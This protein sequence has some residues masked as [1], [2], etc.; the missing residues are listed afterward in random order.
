MDQ[1]TNN[2]EFFTNWESQVKKGL[3]E[4][5][6]SARDFSMS[7][8]KCEPNSSAGCTCDIKMSGKICS[9]ADLETLMLILNNI[10]GFE[11]RDVDFDKVETV[12]YKEIEFHKSDEFTDFLQK[13]N[14]L[15]SGM[16]MY[17]G[18]FQTPAGRFDVNVRGVSDGIIPEIQYQGVSLDAIK[19]EKPIRS[20]F[21]YFTTLPLKEMS[22]SLHQSDILIEGFKNEDNIYFHYGNNWFLLGTWHYQD[23]SGQQLP[24]HLSGGSVTGG[25]LTLPKRY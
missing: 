10:K 14:R 13:K 12:T 11:V 2:K 25:S 6:F 7:L 20:C 1:G 5:G 3:L 16:T 18:A 15:S 4:Q 21:D 17:V 22:S 23:E 8:R 19:V 24:S 9:D